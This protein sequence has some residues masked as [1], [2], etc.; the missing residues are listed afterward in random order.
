M[1]FL[2]RSVL[3]T[4]DPDRRAERTLAAAE[5]NL[6]V[7]AFDKVLELLTALEGGPLGGFARA[8]ADLLLGQIGFAR[9]LGSDAPPQLLKAAKALE[10]FDLDTARDAYLSAWGAALFAGRQSGSGNLAEVS[11]AAL[12]LPRPTPP[13]LLDILLEGL[14]L[15]VTEGRASAAPRLRLAARTFAGGDVAIED[16]LRWGWLAHVVAAELWDEDTWHAI[17]VRQTQVAPEVGALEQL[18]LD[19]N[20]QAMTVTWRGDFSA[21]DLLIAEA[22]TVCEATRTHMAPYAKMFLAA[23]RGNQHEVVALTT[24]AFEEAATG[25]QGVNVPYANWV[26]AVLFNALGRHEE[27]FAAALQAT[28]YMPELFVSTWAVPDLIE[29]AARTGNTDVARAALERLSETAR[30]GGTEHGLG[31]EARSRALLIEGEAAERSYREAIDR[32]GRTR[33]RPELARAHLVYGE[34]LRQRRRRSEARDQLRI[35]AGMFDAMAMEAF[36]ERA[37]SE[38][39]ATGE[40]ARSHTVETYTALTAQEA[41]IATMARDGLSNAEISAR[42]F[43]SKYTVDYHLRKVFSKLGITRRS[44]LVRALPRDPS[45]ALNS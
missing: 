11:R 23:L 39:R 24:A 38:L 26:N 4:A 15:L 44:Q 42:L 7:G 29:A 27:A 41:Q 21:A 2:E 14:A 35:A 30:A 5:A 34:W 16:R 25:G 1:A 8:R 37:R 10:P 40:T 43:V 18:A 33:L 36:A 13:R 3:L 31:L 20:S 12:D 19:L 32:L 45:G 28:E 22:G 9:G 6:R 17:T